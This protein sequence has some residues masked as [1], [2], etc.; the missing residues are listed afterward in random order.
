MPDGVGVGRTEGVGVA[1][2]LVAGA[3][4]HVPVGADAG[5]E[6][7]WLD[8]E[9]NAAG[10]DGEPDGFAP[11]RRNGPRKSAPA[12]TA[13]QRIANE[14]APAALGIAGRLVTSPS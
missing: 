5:E 7:A 6:Y 9:T 10:S 3:G 13:A 12:T 11:P 4:D 8:A 14:I 1:T 2:T